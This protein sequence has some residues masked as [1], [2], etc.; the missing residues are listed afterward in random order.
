MFYTHLHAA[1]VDREHSGEEEHLQEEIGDE[2]HH[3]K[4]TELLQH[5][6]NTESCIKKEQ[7]T[8]EQSEKILLQ[9][10]FE[11]EMWNYTRA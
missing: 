1:D 7:M 8:R 4:Q 10:G 3:S 6:E 9:L 5:E 2:T 11:R